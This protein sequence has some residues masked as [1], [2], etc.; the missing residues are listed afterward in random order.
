[1]S[2]LVFEIGCE[3]IP[4]RFIPGALDQIKGAFIEKTTAEMIQAER[5]EV[6]GAPRRLTL[7]AWGM[8]QRQADREEIKTGPPKRAALDQE[9]N[10]TKAA[11]GFARGQG[12][13]V[14]ELYFQTTE[15]GEVAALRKSIAGRPTLEVLS[16]ILDSIINELQFPKSMRWGELDQRFVRPVHWILASLQ[17]EVVKLSFAG[18]DSSNQSRGHRFESPEPFEVVGPDQYLE[19][20]QQRGVIVDPQQ[21]RSLI[22]DQ[23]ERLAQSVEGK[24]MDDPQLLDEV[25]FITESPHAVLGRFD[26]TYLELPDEVLITPMRQHQKYFSLVDQDGGL[27][28]AFIAV[29]NLGNGDEQIIARG[30]ERVL[31]ARL[32]DAKFFFEDDLRMPLDQ[33]V[34]QLGAVVFQEKLGSYLD[35]VERIQATAAKL[36]RKLAPEKVE[37]VR[38]AAWLCKADLVT[39]MVG[40]FPELQGTMG[41]IYARKQ[42]ESENVALAIAGHYVP[43]SA[44]QEDFD[45]PDEAYL[46]SLADRA[47]T[48]VGCFA[49]GLKPSGAG[50]PY[51]LRRHAIAVMAIISRAGYRLQLDELLQSARVALADKVK[52]DDEL[53]VQIAEFFRDRL[54]YQWTNAGGRPDVADAVLAAGYNDVLDARARFDALSEFAQRPDFEPL[55]VAF[56]RVV[57]IL[58][59]TDEGPVDAAL[60]ES[61]AEHDL[62]AALESH[63]A[64]VDEDLQAGRYI[65]ALTKLVELKGPIDRFFDD[66]MVLCENTDTRLNRIRLLSG[67]AAL[68]MRL[69]DFKRLS[70]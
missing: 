32:D 21:R 68:F 39:Q 11:L 7:L 14:E 64:A 54:Y 67:L 65:A 50:D 8:P 27:L 25:T 4:A 38:R 55:A 28:P 12:V 44:A 62:L 41:T 46:V 60:F 36:A 29:A 52:I 26:R 61:Q 1:M 47:D 66:V 23:L 3:E 57:N 6:V 10:Y 48:I 51:M 17:G 2:D 43:R 40:E 37:S 63:R 18:I 15:K 20:L 69:A 49:A 34:E 30:N 31:K 5:I 53:F 42:G 13:P 22:R 9:G 33:R 58:K 24:V 35:K 19:L 16:S 70:V 45:L 59:Q 56:K